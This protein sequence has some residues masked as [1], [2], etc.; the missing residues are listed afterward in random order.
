[1]EMQILIKLCIFIVFLVFCVISIT[2]LIKHCVVRG[3]SD[4]LT[5]VEGKVGGKEGIKVLHSSLTFVIPFIQRS[6]FLPLTP[7]IININ[8]NNAISK[9]NIR[10]AVPCTFSVA[11]SDN[12]D[13]QIRA[14]TYLP[15]LIHDSRQFENF[16]SDIIF[17]AMR[18]CIATLSIEEMNSDRLRLQELVTNNVKT[19]L[20]KVGLRLI[21]VNINDIKD[22]AGIIENLGKKAESSTR[23][24]AEIE[25]ADAERKGQS[26]VSRLEM[27]K[28]KMLAA[29]E[30]AAVEQENLAQAAIAVSN[31]DKKRKEAE[32]KSNNEAA[33]RKVVLQNEADVRKTEAESKAS[34]EIASSNAAKNAAVAKA[35]NEREAFEA[36]RLAAEAREALNVAEMKAKISPENEKK[37]LEAKAAGEAEGSRLLK[38][39]ENKADAIRKVAEAEA[40]GIKKL[41]EA[42]GSPEAVVFLRM[43]EALPN[44]ITTFAKSIADRKIDNLTVID[45]GDGK[46]LQGLTGQ[47]MNSVPQIMSCLDAIGINTEVLKKKV[48]PSE[49][50]DEYKETLKKGA[51]N[52]RKKNDI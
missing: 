5:V 32:A 40:E 33:A 49:E 44:I 12:P 31:E 17:G 11:V 25:I 2:G 21:N 16:A 8:L 18:G 24:N 52:M 41:I 51:K 43:Q 35:N 30:Q 29:N 10:V 20:S 45:S 3:R 42:A 23:A 7:R 47:L 6:Y 36:Q 48:I 34:A 22:A 9:E 4:A 37:I 14:A 19:E 27:E 13:D 46:G 26:E 50:D 38:E 1:M 28:R 15:A 39:A